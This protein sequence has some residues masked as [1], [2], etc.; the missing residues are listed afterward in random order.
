M[1][2]LSTDSSA[3]STSDDLVQSSRFLSAFSRLGY[4]PGSVWVERLAQGLAPA[5]T[6][7]SAKEDGA[8]DA[9]SPLLPAHRP[10]GSGSA[11]G[12][13]EAPKSTAARAAVALLEALA[14]ME[15]R[16]PERLCT[17]ATAVIAQ[18]GE[19]VTSRGLLQTLVN[20][21]EWAYKSNHQTSGALLSNGCSLPARAL[22]SL[23]RLLP[24]PSQWVRANVPLLE[25]LALAA[26]THLRSA[27]AADLTALVGAF[28]ALR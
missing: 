24:K 20:N 5:L 18:D 10:L 27:T 8:A 14:E 3:A 21:D 17:L 7:L 19:G 13:V 12:D 6:R 2:L 22:A 1:F 15:A 11:Q 16:P 25:R 28:A 26:A 9:P 23:S 4:Q